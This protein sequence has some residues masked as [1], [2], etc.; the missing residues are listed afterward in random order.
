MLATLRRLNA[1]PRFESE[2][3]TQRARMVHVVTM[4]AMAIVTALTIAMM[5]MQ[6]EHRVRMAGV[7]VTIQVLGLL[8]LEAN[9]RGRT[10]L[11]S[12]G[13]VGGIVA[14]IAINAWPAGGVLSP[15]IA[16]YSV[17]VLMAGI[18]IGERAGIIT[19]IVCTAIA[20]AYAV[21]AAFGLLPEQ[22]VFYAPTARWL[23]YTVYLALVVVL[24]RLANEAIAGAMR[25]VARE[26][27]ERRAAQ[28][29][30]A[31]RNAELDRRVKELRL[32]HD[33]SKLLRNRAYEP[34]VLHDLVNLIP[35]AWQYPDVCAARIAYGETEARSDRFRDSRWRLTVPFRTEESDGVIE[36]VY[37][38]ERPDAGEGPFLAEER[39]VLLSLRDMLG[40]WLERDLSERRRRE[41]EGQLRQSQKMEALGTLAGGIAHD[42]NN[43]TAAIVGQ[44]VLGKTEAGEAHPS[45]KAFDAILAASRRASDLVSRILLFSRRQEAERKPMALRPVIEEA[46][47]LLQVGLPKNVKVR[48][49]FDAQLPAISGDA[50]QLFHVV[51]NLGTNAIHALTPGGGTLT[52]SVESLELG[53]TATRLSVD[54]D[55]GQYVRLTVTDTGAGM[56]R[57]TLDRLFEPFYTT[58]GLAGT[59]LGMS[60]VHGIV[61]DHEGA[62]SVESDV[63]K[64]TTVAVYLPALAEAAPVATPSDAQ[65]AT[66]HGNGEHVMYVDDDEALVNTLSRVIRRFGYRCTAYDDPNAAL[67]DFQGN[68]HSFDAVL[69]DY[70]M[71]AMNG[72]TLAQRLREIR[73]EVPIAVV[74]GY[75]ADVSSTEQAGIDVRIAKP[76]S[77]E[78]LTQAL[79][80][81]LRSRR[82]A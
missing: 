54:L 39:A 47:K 32:L 64:G 73:P 26:L 36:V 19:A 21:A 30:L 6:P 4:S 82:A 74:S 27:A 61:K 68:P 76:V 81:L 66:P 71:P 20:L 22:T 12:A 49:S 45:A 59:G 8:V 51:M 75:G 56:S 77:I 35:A 80:T 28:Q 72:V 38:E 33:A 14:L 67:R 1:P 78:V 53:D 37:L 13:I 29:A 43:I 70:M 7:A 46:V 31:E 41:V 5:I 40:A 60:V 63:D 50:S 9:R 18:L 58:K 62:I 52:V 23:L 2:E 65:T 34:A 17:M 55:A 15:G 48:S 3:L 69:T 25:R 10:L 79:R 42:F 16:M 57:E 44:A 11:A 24:M